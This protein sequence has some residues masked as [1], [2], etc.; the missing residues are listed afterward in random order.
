MKSNI[1]IWKDVLGYEGLYK[2]SNLGRIKSLNYRRSGEERLMTLHDN[3]NGYLFVCLTKDKKLKQFY[4]HRVVY[5]AFNGPVPKGLVINHLNE[6]KNDNRLENLE[7]ITHL[8]NCNYGNRNNL[9]SQKRRGKGLGIKPWNNGKKLSEEYKAK[10]RGRTPWNKGKTGIYSNEALNRM[11]LS[12][13]DKT[14]W[15]K[16]IPCSE[17]TKRKISETKQFGKQHA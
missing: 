13:K 16:G 5:E 8:E 2:A 10:L 11:S 3:G 4:V 1:E 17:E 14:P 6:I 12:H 15:N 9:V 7:C